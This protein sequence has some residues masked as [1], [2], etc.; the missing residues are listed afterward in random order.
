M[1]QGSDVIVVSTNDDCQEL[2]QSLRKGKD[3]Y[4]EMPFK[5]AVVPY[6]ILIHN[7]RSDDINK[8]FTMAPDSV[9]RLLIIG[10]TGGEVKLNGLTKRNLLDLKQLQVTHCQLKEVPSDVFRHLRNLE[11]LNLSHK[12]LKELPELVGY[13]RNLREIHL[14]DNRLKWNWKPR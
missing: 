1:V 11:L 9:E 10:A 6:T 2:L 4:S 8:I 7:H 13:L 5:N 12:N 3:C 14:Q